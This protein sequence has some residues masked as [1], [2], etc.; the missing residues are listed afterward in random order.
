MDENVKI[1]VVT[2]TYNSGKVLPEFLKCVFGQSHTNFVLFA[3]DNASKDST[4]EQLKN[5][6]DP[7]LVVI[8][9][10]ENK[11]VAEGNNQ[12]IN[13][14]LEAK[15]GSILLINNDTE[16]DNDLFEKLQ[17]GLLQYSADMTC[18][19]MMFFD[20]PHR[21]WAAGGNF[22][23]WLCYRIAQR[24][25]FVDRGQYDSVEQITYAPTCCVLIRSDL[26][27]RIGVM[28]P[29]YF[30][31]MDDV[32]F[33]FRALKAGA[34][35]MYLPY[36]KLLHK[37]SSLSGGKHSATE[38]L[39]C[40][41]NRVYFLLKNFGFVRAFSWICLYEGYLCAR[42]L[43]FRDNVRTFKFKQKAFLSGLSMLK[44]SS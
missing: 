22:Q 29:K 41:R 19:K 34:K 8:A 31:Y 15:C 26:F 21:V 6:A 12:G 44:E 16:F 18:P 30:V 14:A 36:C 11:G 10:P 24:G 27:A 5:C 25:E 43:I 35:L 13:A 39:Y 40:T 4:V 23:P 38:V 33:M 1:G 37:V 7:R 3:I 9:N 42:L 17:A 32:D 28:D 20:E 2:V